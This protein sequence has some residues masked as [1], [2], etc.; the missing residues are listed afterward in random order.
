MKKLNYGTYEE[1][2]DLPSL[3]IIMNPKESKGAVV[4]IKFSSRGDFL[5][6]SYDNEKISGTAGELRTTKFDASFVQ[7]F[8]NRHS[9]KALNY[10]SNSKSLYVK[11]YKIVL[12]LADFHS[13]IEKRNATA[14]AQMDF[15]HDDLFILMCSMRINHEN[16]RDYESGED[17]LA[18]W[19]IENNEI[20]NDYDQLKK[21]DWISWTI[22]NSIYSRFLGNTL[23]AE[24]PEEESK[25]RA[26][27]DCIMSGSQ[28]FPNL[29]VAVCGNTQGDVFLF[30]F[31]CLFVDK[32]KHLSFSV[33]NIQKKDMALTRSYSAHS[34][35]VMYADLF[36]E[37]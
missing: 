37:D 3:D 31:P 8:V 11:A 1:E 15:S 25:L 30:R 20:V 16:V 26:A 27:E 9:S 19:D 33:D 28:K 4:C 34:S 14:V 6:V 18:V 13:S 12:P 32:S 17:I 24:N 21:S 23:Q 29:R 5:A 7:L 35:M 36:R 22:S 10:P 2:F